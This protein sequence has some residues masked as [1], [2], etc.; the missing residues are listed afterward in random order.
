MKCK[1]CN[2]PAVKDNLCKKHLIEESEKVFLDNTSCDKNMGIIKWLKYMYP[3]HFRNE[4]TQ[5]HIEVYI[6]LL[7]LYDPRYINK[8]HRLRE[9]I[10]FRGFSKSKI[11]FGIISY[12]IAHN[13]MVM[14]IKSV[15]D[16]IF[17]VEINEKYIVLFSETATMAEE[18]VTNIR[19]EFTTNNRLKYFYHFKIEEAIDDITGQ[20]TRKAFKMNDC[21]IVGLGAKQQAR[22]KIK[23]AYR[24]TFIF[25]DDIYS[26]NNTITQESRYSIKRWFYDS[27]IN[28]GDDLLCKVLLVGTIVHEDTVLIEC[29]KSSMWKTLKFYPMPLDKFR[30]VVDKYLQVDYSLRTCKLPFEE[31]EDEFVR[32]KK[33]K[34]FF[35]K[36]NQE[37]EVL[38][39]DRIGLYE[40]LLKYK[41]AVEN[42]NLSGFYREYFHQVIPQELKKFT[43]DYF[44]RVNC[45]T[46]FKYGYTWLNID[47]DLQ[48]T[49]IEI[50]V[51]IA[52]GKNEGDN[53]AIVVVGALPNRKI[54][55]L[56][57]V[58][59]KLSI[60]DRENQKGYID[61]L[62]RLNARYKPSK[63]KIGF[64]GGHE[65]AIIEELRRVFYENNVYTIILPRPQNR[66]EGEKFER[67]ERTLLPKYEAG[68]ILHNGSFIELEYELEF[69]RKAKNDDLADALEVAIW[70]INY[71]SN[72]PIKF[73]EGNKGANIKYYQDYYD[74]LVS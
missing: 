16:N 38:W 63:I 73:F 9:L 43:S 31:I 41:E 7:R 21:F 54:V 14:K 36:L 61:E 52:G 5:A 72:I 70:N 22:G 29:E 27:A 6:E 48:L 23:G 58:Y 40:L 55:V 26:E 20:W 64:G 60:R 25:F 65:G 4:F 28:T 66:S 11:I 1:F 3:E 17:D 42:Q 53:T 8:Q 59:G 34:E 44:K 12:L 62:L 47:N 74:W 32:I 13:G 33:Q 46:E 18:F 56:D 69:L 15:D 49:N 39:G 51:D 24:P 35:D 68:D 57:V 30:E 37:Y 50:G 71:P 2:L 19:D 67:I 45:K 10:A